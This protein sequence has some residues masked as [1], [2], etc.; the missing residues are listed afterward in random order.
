MRGVFVTFEGI[1]GSGKS[2]QVELLARH[3][4]E[5]GTAV[6][7]TREPGGTPLGERVR[8]ILLDPASDPVPL[9]ELFLLEAARAQLV[10]RVI[11]PALAAGTTVLSDRFADSS[12]AY[13]GAA[14]GLG[15]EVVATLN[16]AAC[17]AT[18]PDRTVL[19]DL[20][21]DTALARARSRPSTT[22]ANR[23]FEDEALAFHRSVAAGYREAA[24]REPGRFRVVDAA[25]APAAVHRR[26]LLALGDLLP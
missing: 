17:G 16:A 21:V 8:A 23:R 5:R 22:A 26:V 19:L 7:T 4:A 12:T 13:Q 14:R 2:T 11:E 1:E 9:S 25:G 3:L 6:A 20:D 18:R 10:A 15:G 24:R